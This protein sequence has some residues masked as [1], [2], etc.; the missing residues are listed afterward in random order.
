MQTAISSVLGALRDVNHRTKLYNIH[1][2][3][4]ASS[5][6]STT[7]RA[8]WFMCVSAVVMCSLQNAHYVACVRAWVC[9][10]GIISYLIVGGIPRGSIF[11]KFTLLF[12]TL[13]YSRQNDAI[14]LILTIRGYIVQCTRLTRPYVA[15]ILGILTYAAVNK[16]KCQDSRARTAPVGVVAL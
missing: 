2:A 1:T 3:S 7:G 12:Y 5:A 6:S 16:I 15:T 10:C 13:I 11:L 14:T 8:S 9:V 4:R